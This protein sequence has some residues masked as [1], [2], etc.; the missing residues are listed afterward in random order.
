[1]KLVGKL[2]MP[3]KSGVQKVSPEHQAANAMLFGEMGDSEVVTIQT[4]AALT[5]FREMALRR[6][7][8]V[9]NAVG[10]YTHGSIGRLG[11]VKWNIIDA[12]KHVW[13]PSVEACGW[14]PTTHTAVHGD[15]ISVKGME[16][17]IEMCDKDLLDECTREFFGT[18]V[19][20]EK[21]YSTPQGKKI[22]DSFIAAIYEGKGDSLY[23]LLDF[24]D[25]PLIWA[26][27]SSGNHGMSAEEFADYTRQQQILGGWLTLIDY[28]KSIGNEQYRVEI[29]PNHI[30]GGEY[31]GDATTLLKNVAKAAPA[32]MKGLIAKSKMK[33][34][35]GIFLVSPSI[36]SKYEDELMAAD[37][38]NASCVTMNGLS[39]D[40]DTVPG[41]LKFRGDYVLN[42]DQWAEFDKIVKVHTHR[43]LYLVPGALTFAYDVP[44][45]NA[46]GKD[47][48]GL[49]V[50]TSKDIKD[51]FKTYILGEMELGAGIF[52]NSIVNASISVPFTD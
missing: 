1:M 17:N 3:V 9:D 48:A 4:G 27:Q 37:M 30:S 12:P 24:G 49:L 38:L 34:K 35:P 10:L 8:E 19:D 42:R 23:E 45:L 16:L 6:P 20:I 13:Q 25:H 22:M 50:Q 33:G 15:E 41:V 5:F 18:G 44:V 40:T 32:R 43:V 46:Y 11:K 51:K 28:Q 31:M 52:K 7:R 36:F 29:N 21:L 26:A 39:C 14:N 47:K 2:N